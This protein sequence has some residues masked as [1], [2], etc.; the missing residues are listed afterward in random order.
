METE[1]KERSRQIHP[2][3][4]NHRK[5]IVSFHRADEFAMMEFHSHRKMM[6]YAYDLVSAGYRVQ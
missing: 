4:V 6:L 2:L 5:R 3:W 1:K